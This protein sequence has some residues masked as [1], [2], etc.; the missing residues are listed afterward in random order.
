M[1]IIKATIEDIETLVKLRVDCMNMILGEMTNEQKASLENQMRS[2][3]SRALPEGRFEAFMAK[4]DGVIASAAFM[5]INER[6]ASP[7]FLTGLTA[8]VVN[9]MTY[10]EY[11]RQGFAASVLAA[12]IEEAKRR[13]ITMLDLA[14]TRA[15]QKLYETVGFEYPDYK[16]MRMYL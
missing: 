7:H 1:E 13:N 14:A 2:Y 12:V 16:L 8:T 6:P 4:A 15:G 10:P 11:R 3:V 9:V 5:V